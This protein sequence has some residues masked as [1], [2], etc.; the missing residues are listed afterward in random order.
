V[1][2]QYNP[3]AVVTNNSA[4][5]ETRICLQLLLVLLLRLCQTSEDVHDTPAASQARKQPTC[6][7][8]LLVQHTYLH[9]GSI[10]HVRAHKLCWNGPLDLQMDRT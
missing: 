4:A 6:W 2:T 5:A 7:S 10:A 1:Q 8:V 9:A 3:A